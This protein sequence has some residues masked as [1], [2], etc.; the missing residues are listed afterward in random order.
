MLIAASFSPWTSLPGP[1]FV[2]LQSEACWWDEGADAQK[3]VGWGRRAENPSHVSLQGWAVGPV[4]CSG[5]R[6]WAVWCGTSH[7]CCVLCFSPGNSPTS[8]LP[9]TSS[10]AN[11]TRKHTLLKVMLA[12]CCPF[13]RPEFE[14]WGSVLRLFCFR[15]QQYFYFNFVMVW[16]AAVWDLW[17]SRNTI[18]PWDENFPR[19]ASGRSWGKTEGEFLSLPPHP[20]KWVREESD[21]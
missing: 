12:C 16:M 11:T 6:S 8:C 1:R 21:S 13:L 7:V 18:Y 19:I 15:W 5:W 17:E 9:C 2:C 14:Y 10:V 20:W 3:R 4:V